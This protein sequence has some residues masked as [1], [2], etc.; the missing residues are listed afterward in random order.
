M[1][2]CNTVMEKSLKS[3]EILSQQFRGNPVLE[4][5]IIVVYDH[6]PWFWILHG[7]EIGG[8]CNYALMTF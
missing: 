7:L 6:G 1:E 3:H 4:I 5:H 8:W 2:F